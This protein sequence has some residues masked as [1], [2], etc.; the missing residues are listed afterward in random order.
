MTTLFQILLK[1]AIPVWYQDI[2]FYLFAITSLLLLFSWVYYIGI[3][4]K[5]SAEMKLI[6][7]QYTARV[8]NIRK[9]H[10][11]T[12][13]RIRV[14]ML[15]REEERGRQWMESEKE[16]LHVLSGISTLLD[17]SEKIGRVESE[18]ILKKL[19]EITEKVE[20]ITSIE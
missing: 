11:E 7:Q 10:A 12:L 8:D 13:E 4:R 16:T 6:Q 18:K 1:I 17:L 14:E 9:E 15:K 19:E 20:K 2:F 3:F 5:R